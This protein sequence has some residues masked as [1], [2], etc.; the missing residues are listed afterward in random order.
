MKQIKTLL[1]VIFVALVGFIIVFFKIFAAIQPAIPASQ[2]RQELSEAKP[3]ESQ[4]D[5]TID[6]GNNSPLTF[7]YK[8]GGHKT[9]FDA[10][11]DTALANNISLETQNYEF[12]VFV[13][14]INGLESTA[15]KS[16]IYFVNGESGMVAADKNEIKNGDVVEWKYLPPTEE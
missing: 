2:S 16:W 13:K 14:S 9:V 15:K 10:L 8:F 12:G 3:Q 4:I 1:F 5:L 11:K 7:E 6:S